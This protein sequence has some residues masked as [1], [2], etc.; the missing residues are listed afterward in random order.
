MRDYY[1]GELTKYLNKAEELKKKLKEPKKQ[2]VKQGH[3]T[4]KKDEK[5]EKGGDGDSKDEMDEELKKALEGVIVREKP[6][7][8]WDDVAGLELAKR[9]LHEAIVLPLQFPSMY[10]KM[11]IDPHKGILM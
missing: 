11:N 5:G 1:A 8:H 9:A 10:E 2:V 7:L 6:D 4:S 3:G